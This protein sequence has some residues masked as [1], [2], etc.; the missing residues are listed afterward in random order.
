AVVL[1]GDRQSVGRRPRQ[2][3]GGDELRQGRG[4]GLQGA[5]HDG[6]LVENANSTTVVHVV[7]LTSHVVRRKFVGGAEVP[8]SRHTQEPVRGRDRWME[9]DMAGT[10]AEKVWDAHVV[11]R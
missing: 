9:K 2:T 4:A 6:G 5:E 11:R 1:E 3:R 8:P 10:L 7:I